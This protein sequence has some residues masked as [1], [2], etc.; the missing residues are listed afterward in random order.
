MR[1]RR[2]QAPASRLSRWVRSRTKWGQR[3]ESV[4]DGPSEPKPGPA[5]SSVE[6]TDPTRH[7][8]GKKGSTSRTL[9]SLPGE[10]GPS[11]VGRWGWAGLRATGQVIVMEM[12]MTRW[13][14]ADFTTVTL[15]SCAM[16]ALV[17]FCTYRNSS[18]L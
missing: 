6:G 15:D 16:S 14:S 5:R 9:C 11:F 18:T 7:R 10:W 2:T 12:T 4:L 3:P 1:S 17:G 13:L 8:R